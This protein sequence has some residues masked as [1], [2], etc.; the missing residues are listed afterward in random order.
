MNT[1]GVDEPPEMS[2]AS[3]ARFVSVFVGADVSLTWM[4]GYCFSDALISTC[5][6][7]VPLV[8]IGLAHQVID[9][10]A[11]LDADGADLDADGAAAGELV[12]PPLLQ[13]ATARAPA[14]PARAA[15]RQLRNRALPDFLGD[16][17]RVIRFPTKSSYILTFCIVD[18]SGQ[19]AMH[20]Q[21]AWRSGSRSP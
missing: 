3:V 19:S 2:V 10:D 14:T 9:P 1:S 11:D 16:P 4:F 21:V 20:A 12:L 17:V 13:P 8:L 18:R 15:S 5:R 7:S 6:T